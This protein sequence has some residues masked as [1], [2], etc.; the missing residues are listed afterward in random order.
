MAYLSGR[1]AWAVAVTGQAKEAGGRAAAGVGTLTASGGGSTG[2]RSLAWARANR[3]TLDRIG[4]A[5]IAFILLWVVAGFWVAL[6]G[7]ALVAVL[8]FGLGLLGGNSNPS[9]EPG[10]Q[11]PD[12]TAPPEG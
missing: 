4:I 2:E 10:G 5:A 7:A 1:P 11:R 9:T 12:G 8:Q 3:R 6:L